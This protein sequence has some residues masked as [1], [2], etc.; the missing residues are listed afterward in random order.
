MASFFENKDRNVIPNWRSFDTTA[1]LGELSRFHLDAKVDTT[2]KVDLTDLFDSWEDN[3]TMGLAADII[4]SAVILNLN[5]DPKLEAVSK[6]IC[7]N[8]ENA[9]PVLLAAVKNFIGSENGAEELATS[10]NSL[11][12]FL[13][14]ESRQTIFQNINFTKKRLINNPKNAILWVELARL[15]SILG[16]DKKAERSIL[17]ALQ[18]SKNN[19]YVLRSIARFFVH[20]K[21]IDFAH[22]ILKNAEATGTDSWLMATE[23]SLA[24]MRGRGSKFAKKG[25]EII[26]SKASSPFNISELASAVATTE[27]HNGSAKKSKDFFKTSLIKPNDNALAQA[28]WVSQKEVSF[29]N[30]N[31]TSFNTVNSY[32]ALARD[33][34]EKEM[35]LESYEYSVKWF[36]DMPFSKVPILFGSHVAG[37]MLNNN[38][39]AV[40][41]CKA[42]LISHPRD[43][44][45]INNILYSLCVLNKLGEA[46]SYLER[47]KTIPID[48]DV[49]KTCLTATRG[50]YFF[51]KGFHDLGRDF[52]KQAIELAGEIKNKYLFN[53]AFVNYCREEVLINSEYA[54]ELFE[55]M[56]VILK[57]ETSKDITNLKLEVIKLYQKNLLPDQSK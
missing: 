27:F 12:N 52:Y 29:M 14:D 28:E 37:A 47:V 26:N 25:I 40:E 24:L 49:N 39:K 19:R 1:K 48:N 17:N 16:Q 41:I 13:E 20:N 8:K 30:V 33:C 3:Q 36:L 43:L 11:E 5:S 57:G 15:Y 4:S 21:N 53:L 6:F 32:E 35:Y 46:E 22:D 10:V 31:P 38:E 55:S 51:R 7:D 50:L 9:S 56:D 2:A 18:L 23:I 42:G 54:K 45:L 44:E 34:F